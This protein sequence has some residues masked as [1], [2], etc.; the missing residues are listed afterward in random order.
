[1]M[2]MISDEEPL[3]K[4]VLDLYLSLTGLGRWKD[5]GGRK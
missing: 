2:P 5:K 3:F 4:V 1:M